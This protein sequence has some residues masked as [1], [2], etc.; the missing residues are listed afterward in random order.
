MGSPVH[1]LI[2]LLTLWDFRL[3][4]CHWIKLV[5][6]ESSTKSLTL[7]NLDLSAIESC[8][9]LI[10]TAANA[11]SPPYGCIPYTYHWS[12]SSNYSSTQTD[13][14][15][16]ITS[17]GNSAILTIPG[18]KL[19]FGT[20]YDFIVT[21]QNANFVFYTPAPTISFTTAGGNTCQNEITFP[22]FSVSHNG[23]NDISKND[24]I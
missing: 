1:E 11:P 12:F 24:L 7:F 2:L 21:I 6:C 17:T 18:G 14:D 10:I 15:S 20:Q 3:S 8:K 13:L 5:I 23:N 19:K 4:R 22:S 9:S 16:L